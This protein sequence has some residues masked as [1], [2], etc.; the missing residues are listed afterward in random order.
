MSGIINQVGARSGI[1]SGG[2]SASA[3][4]VTLS[5]ITGLDYE[6]GT[7]TPIIYSGA[8][9]ITQTTSNASTSFTYVKIG[10]FVTVNF[11]HHAETSSGTTGGEF[12]IGGL[13][14]ASANNF[15]GSSER[16]TYWS[17]GLQISDAN[18]AFDLNQ[19]NTLATCRTQ[20]AAGGYVGGC[21]VTDVGSGGYLWFS[22]HYQTDA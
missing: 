4:T 8:N 7:W 21:T 19:N 11:N 22:L 6:E 20:A 18:A 13:P 2:G 1:I 12:K 9:V 10:R 14:Y 15:R 17:S 3:G 16:I 5:G